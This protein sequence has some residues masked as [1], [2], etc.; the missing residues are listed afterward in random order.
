MHRYIGKHVYRGLEEVD[1]IR[2]ATPVETESGIGSSLI[3]PPFAFSGCT[4]LMGMHRLT[5]LISSNK[6]HIMVLLILIDKLGMSEGS[7]NIRIQ[8]QF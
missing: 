5:S 3:S 1:L 7:Q 4:S 6:D 2:L 8:I